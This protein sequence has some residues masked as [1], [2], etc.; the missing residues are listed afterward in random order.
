MKLSKHL[1]D[2]TLDDKF[3][4][5]SELIELAYCP[6]FIYFMNSL[7]IPQKE[8]NRWL[9]QS[10]INVH[11]N[12]ASRNKGYLRTKLGVT[13]KLSD[14]DLCSEK[15]KIKGR[16]DE[17]LFLNNGKACILDYKNS[18]F[19]NNIY[20]TVKI[21][22]IAYCVMASETYNIVA[23]KAYVIYL[24]SRNSIELTIGSQDI[25][26]LEEYINKYNK[27]SSGY[28][29]LATKTKSRCDDCCYKNI[30]PK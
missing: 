28:F 13:G 20:D 9:V 18:F 27:I 24:K 30:C 25:K 15:Y 11:K 16:V 6:R 7:S 3:I 23:D 8:E 10:G 17:L 1:S 5:P 14:I 4:T 22:M 12:R 29:P 26:I 21:Q 19:D 2:V